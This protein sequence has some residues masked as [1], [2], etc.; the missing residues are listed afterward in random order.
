MA[1]VLKVKARDELVRLT[2]LELH[3]KFVALNAKQQ[4]I[5]ATKFY[6]REI[7][8]PI[9]TVIDDDDIDL[10]I[11]DG[12]NDLG[13]D[14]IH[15]DDG[16]VLV[17]QSKYR[18]QGT[19]EK[20]EEITRFRN[21][22]KSFRDTKQKSNNRLADAIASI[23]WENDQFELVFITFGKINEQARA[24]SQQAP[25][26]PTD[27]PDLDERCDWRFLDETDINVA[28]RNAHSVAAGI[29]KMPFTLHPMGTKGQR[30]HSVI[31]VA[32]G[33]HKSY[34]M[35]LDANQLVNAYKALGQDAIFSLNIR[36][37][38]GKTQTNKKILETA[39]LDPENFY[40]FNNGNSCLATQ[41]TVTDNAVEVVG[42]QVINGAQT[43]RSLV[44]V[45]QFGSHVP[46]VL[47]RVTEIAEGYGSGGKIREQIT[48][49][50]NTQNTIKLSD[51]R[52]NDPVQSALSEQF[53][54]IVRSGRKVAYLPKRTDKIPANHE[55]VRLEEFAKSVYA[56][57]HGPT[58]FT[59]STS[60]LF[61]DSENGGYAAVFGDGTHVWER[62][63]EAEFEMRA[64]MYW[65]A[66]EFGAQ[67]R[68][69]RENTT[70]FDARAALERK[71]L[72]IYAAA[73]CFEY[74]Y[75]GDG[76]KIQ[77]RKLYRGDWTVSGSDKKSQILAN[78][79]RA[80][81]AGVTTA[82]K[83]ERTNNKSFEHRR[84][85]RSK[86]TPTRIRTVLNDIVLPLQ[87]P[88]DDI[89]K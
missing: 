62:M 15:R 22:L 87:P 34:V 89:P 10:G 5:A 20:T 28:L 35:T 57:L 54:Q 42:L 79:F 70:D 59:A 45:G 13:C 14:F 1:D 51:F 36:N 68:A 83:N 60:F 24:V 7:H 3:S 30:A 46:F 50:N 39:R 9:A 16:R 84:W 47:V 53:K 82:Y 55:V 56:F 4:S 85:I 19:S 27:V 26:Y 73:C 31:S 29:S 66:Q 64:A 88:L 18:G 6:V 11:V 75:K 43:I 58:E 49:F 72:L 17:I 37:Y 80:S 67:L 81:V 48:R 78:V 71:W 69:T 76:W 23:D 44:H 40:M 25:D 38:V 12:G 32:A 52:S 41:V 74:C 8:N 2:E 77:L 21:V 33:N 63:P 61:D 65:I 86:E